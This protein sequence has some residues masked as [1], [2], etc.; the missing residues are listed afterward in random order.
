MLEKRSVSNPKRSTKGSYTK[1]AQQ[2]EKHGVASNRMGIAYGA[3][4]AGRGAE[5]FEPHDHV[6]HSHGSKKAHPTK[7]A[8]R[9]T[10]EQRIVS[11]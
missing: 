8:R 10:R 4:Q 9:K 11:G 7:G 5:H 1:L 6:K 2:H 3:R